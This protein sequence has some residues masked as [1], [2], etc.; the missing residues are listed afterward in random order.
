MNGPVTYDFYLGRGRY[1]RWLGSAHL[2]HCRCGHLARLVRAEAPEEY[3]GLVR[4]FL[5]EL[6]RDRAGI[7]HRG[8]EWP[9]PWP[10][11]HGTDKTFAF[12][13]GV[14]WVAE[15]G[16]TWAPA[17]CEPR[18][19]FA[20]GREFVVLPFMRPTCGFT[21]V[22][23][24]DTLARQYGPLLGDSY[25]LDLQQL[26][27]RILADLT[28]VTPPLPPAWGGDRWVSL[29]PLRYAITTDEQ[30]VHISIDVTT[31]GEPAPPGLHDRLAGL[32][33]LYGWTD[34]DGGPPRFTVDTA[35]A[36]RHD[37][38]ADHHTRVTIRS[39]T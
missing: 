4:G 24:R 23:T 28:L 11:S 38:F 13:N 9:W 6:E 3:T 32:P 25:D 30:A 17:G 31:D 14:V 20:V 1:A 21:G 27:I 19:P 22:D 39:H 7:A 35:F 18:H 36:D 26:A 2:H 16:N 8:D 29:P 15:R 5:A 33:A 37:V 34:P 12:D 10:T